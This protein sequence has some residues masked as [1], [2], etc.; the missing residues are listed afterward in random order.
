MIGNMGGEGLPAWIERVR[1]DDLPA[2]HA[3]ATGLEREWDA[4]VAGLMLPWS[5]GPTEGAVNRIK[6][7]KRSMYGRATLDLLRLRILHPV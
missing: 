3:F 5:N 1:A 7:L 4:V 6:A 2:L